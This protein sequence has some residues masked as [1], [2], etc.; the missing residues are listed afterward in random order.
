MADVYYQSAFGGLRL[1]LGS[2]STERSRSQ[3]VHELSAGDEYV[4]QDRGRGPRRVRCQVL[5]DWMD[6]DDLSPLERARKLQALVDDQPRLFT[7]PIDG[8]F[9]AR[10]GPF[11]DQLDSSGTLTAQLDFIAVSDVQPISPNGAGGIPPSVD[12]A[13]ASAAAA[14]QFEVDG[15]TLEDSDPA[16]LAQQAADAAQ[17][18]ATSDNLNARDVLAQTGSLTSS[19]G[20]Q[21]DSM[22]NDIS[23]WSAFKAT[24]LLAET[25]RVAAQAATAGT[26]A[27]FLL[28]IGSPVALRALLASVYPADEAAARYDQVMQLNDIATPAWLAAGAELQLPL[29]TP[30]ARVG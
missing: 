22:S 4:V 16:L 20:A 9:L 8:T 1:W 6:G 30:G 17:D 18:W 27:T 19:L 21:A 11:N 12:G 28:R 15:L 23:L 26:A 25:V 10:V 24:V 3:V 7:H 13:V 2:I 29:P 5:F 14:L